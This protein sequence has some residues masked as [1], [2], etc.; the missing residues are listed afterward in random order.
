[1]TPL[2]TVSAPSSR[3]FQA[4]IPDGWRRQGRGILKR[5]RLERG[6]ESVDERVRLLT[7]LLQ[8]RVLLGELKKNRELRTHECTAGNAIRIDFRVMDPQIR[9][10]AFRVVEFQILL[11]ASGIQD[12]QSKTDPGASFQANQTDLLRPGSD[13]SRQ[14]C[15]IRTQWARNQD[16]TVSIRGQILP[17]AAATSFT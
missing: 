6:L 16:N 11:P 17:G 8:V 4:R 3:Q 10:E 13:I 7:R 2:S 1:M 12:V 5:F 9:P 15:A 14:W